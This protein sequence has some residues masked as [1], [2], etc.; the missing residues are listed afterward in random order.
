MTPKN[1][2]LIK[3]HRN[4][5]NQEEDK[6]AKEW[7]ERIIYDIERADTNAQE[8]LKH[9]I[10]DYFRFIENIPEP[11]TEMNKAIKFFLIKERDEI[12]ALFDEVKK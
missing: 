9:R 5:Q 7:I 11:E 3:N 4:W 10:K 1:Q 2:E 6:K 12:L 8:Y